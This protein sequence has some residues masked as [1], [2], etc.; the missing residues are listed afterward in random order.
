MIINTKK[1]NQ[2]KKV[3]VASNALLAKRP[4]E[5]R[6][7]NKKMEI[8]NCTIHQVNGRILFKP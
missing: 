1:K 6:L 2:S 8:H 7:P 5:S 3:K 4:N